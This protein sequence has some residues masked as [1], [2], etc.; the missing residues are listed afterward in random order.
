MMDKD[1]T[2]KLTY[3]EFRD[4]FRTLSYGL[5]DNDINMLIALA[6]EDEDELISWQEFIPIGIDA[7]KNFYTRNLVKQ[8][9]EAMS[10]PNPDALKLVYWDE[11]LNCTKLLQ[12]KFEEV[13]IVKDGVVSLQHFKN[14]IRS[15]KFLTP[16]EKNL[17]IRLQKGDRI[18]YS[19]LPEMIYNVRYEIASSE[20]ME[21]NMSELEVYIVKE[22]AMMDKDDSGEISIQ[23]CEIALNRCK[24]INLTT[25]QIHILLGLSDCDG[26]G[27]V[28]YRQFAK[29]CKEYIEN[30]FTFESMSK[31]AKLAVQNEK[32][33]QKVHNESVDID[34][35]EIFRTFK[36][37]DRNMN[38]TLDF[39]E[40]T[41]CLMECPNLN[42]SKQEII[43][44]AMSADLNGDGEIDFE[45]FMKHFTSVL[46]MIQYQKSLQGNYQEVMEDEAKRK[47]LGANLSEVGQMA[48]QELDKMKQDA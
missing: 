17:L 5:N 14:I 33:I 25:F 43:T 20:M 44:S 24:K 32:N 13:D 28:P 34:T 35:I 39:S 3:Q 27:Q 46:N 40:Y 26:D 22:F 9:A 42:L 8:K 23:D 30:S 1:K 37:Y 16:K 45:E 41:Q 4:A 10:H 31:K 18:K 15:T 21:S 2:G 36:K 11:I 12:Y 19:E 47:A 38:G 6:D 29:V 48:K 7:I